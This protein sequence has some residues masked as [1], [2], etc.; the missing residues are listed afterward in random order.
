MGFP[1][2]SESRT[3]DGYDRLVSVTDSQ[4]RVTQVKH[5]A[6]DVVSSVRTQGSSWVVNY[7]RDDFARVT[8][9]WTNG[10][11]TLQL[12]R[13][14][15]GRVW[16]KQPLG[17]EPTYVTYDDFGGAAFVQQGTVKTVRVAPAD[18]RFAGSAR[19]RNESQ[20]KTSN[21]EQT[22]SV[23]GDPLSELEIGYDGTATPPSRSSTFTRDDNGFMSFTTDALGATS[24]YVRDFLGRPTTVRVPVRA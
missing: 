24:E 12:W 4:G 19:V 21:L 1:I 20:L 5:S 10:Q 14:P 17:A 13:K 15:G 11:R 6:R 16:K 8:E 18:L 9:Q 3:Y 7:V 22:L 23:L 2:R